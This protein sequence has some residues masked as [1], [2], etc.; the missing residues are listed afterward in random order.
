MPRTRS[1]VSEYKGQFGSV[2]LGTDVLGTQGVFPGISPVSK[3]GCTSCQAT[4]VQARAQDKV[5]FAHARSRRTYG[6]IRITQKLKA[7][8]LCVNEK[9]VGQLTRE[10]GLRAKAGRKYQATT[11]SAHSRPVAPTTLDREFT[12]TA[13]GLGISTTCGPRQGGCILPSSLT[14]SSARLLGSQFIAG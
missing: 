5:R 8:G 11:D 3:G 6:R 7:Q 13:P 9:R 1:K 2:S 4:E 12:A 14:C 10:E